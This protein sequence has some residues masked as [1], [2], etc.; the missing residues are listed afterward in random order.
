MDIR[1]IEIGTRH[2]IKI[3]MK[4]NRTQQDV[5]DQGRLSKE[6]IS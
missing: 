4:I 5:Q 3:L 2:G 6:G 1:I